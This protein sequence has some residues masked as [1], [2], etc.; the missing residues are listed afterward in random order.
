MSTGNRND[1]RSPPFSE[2]REITGVAGDAIWA[3]KP[4]RGIRIIAANSA[5]AKGQ[6]ETEHRTH[7]LRCSG[8]Y[9]RRAITSFLAR[10]PVVPTLLP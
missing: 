3:D 9:I 4:A 10:W 7:Q 8:T 5:Q 2:P 1:I 6:V